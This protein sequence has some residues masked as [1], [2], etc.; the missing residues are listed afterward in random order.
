MSEKEITG[1]ESGKTRMNLVFDWNWGIIS[2]N[3]HFKNIYIQYGTESNIDVGSCRLV[4]THII[5]SSVCSAG[6]CR[7]IPPH[8]T[9]AVLPVL[10]KLE[11]AFLSPTQGSLNILFFLHGMFFPSV[12]TCTKFI[13]KLNSIT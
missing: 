7:D 6:R 3:K 12:L 11:R 1:K 5:L 10:Q 9:V 4:Y 13:L 8:T 2:M